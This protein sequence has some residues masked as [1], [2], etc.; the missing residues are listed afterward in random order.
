MQVKLAH[1]PDLLALAAHNPTRYP[2]LFQ[3]LGAK[4]GAQ[5]PGAQQ[6]GAW[7]IAAQW[8][9]LAFA[10]GEKIV[11]AHADTDAFFPQLETALAH[12]ANVPSRNIAPFEPPFRGG[13]VVYLGYEL[14]AEIEPTL[15][16][17][18]NDFGFPRAFALRTPG[19]IAVN[20]DTQ[21]ALLVCE[22]GFE[23]L[24]KQVL[25]DLNHGPQDAPP[26]IFPAPLAAKI[27]VDAPERFLAGV[28]KIHD[29]LNAG[30][31]F[32]AN[33]S[34]GW[35]A[36]LRAPLA[37]ETSAAQIY[38]NLRAARTPNRVARR[39]RT[40]PANR[41]YPRTGNQRSAA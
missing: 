17:A 19:V 5:R 22:P 3:S 2:A 15:T 4:T 9:F 38:G 35:R 34:R 23:A 32:Q 39:L 13:W 20:R 18:P 7:Q 31:V 25:L 1:T 28:Q 11:T 27:S 14:S 26:A 41:R 16:L 24:V 12:T 29:Y 6:D 10:S 36:E 33:L 37:A 21:V 8:D 30:D 40:N